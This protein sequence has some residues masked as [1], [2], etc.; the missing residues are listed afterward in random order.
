VL[1][2]SISEH[3]TS[4]PV[5]KTTCANF[6]KERTCRPFSS[7]AS[8]SF[9]QVPRFIILQQRQQPDTSP[10]QQFASLVHVDSDDRGS[11]SDHSFTEFKPTDI[12][13]NCSYVCT[14]HYAQLWHTIQHRSSDNLPSYHPNDHH[15]S[16]VVYR[17]PGQISMFTLSPH[18]A[19]LSF[20][21]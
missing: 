14:Y 20:P 15:R 6:A 1:C 2:K 7:V 11:A 19:R 13:K 16:E 17:T 10:H 4:S 3:T 9:W 21:K 12:Y 5:T 18:R 8:R